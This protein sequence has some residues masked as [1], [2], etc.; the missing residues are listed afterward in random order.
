M[1]ILASLVDFYL[2]INYNMGVMEIK[3]RN[4]FED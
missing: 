2:C 4:V 1:G 3:G